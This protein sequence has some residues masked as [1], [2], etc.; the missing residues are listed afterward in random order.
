MIVIL[1]GAPG[2]GKGTQSKA[3][4]ALYGF[5]HLST[6]DIFRAE[7]AQKTELGKKAS[8]YVKSGK[9]VP[10][11]VVTEMVAGKLEPGRR[12]LLDGFPRNVEQAR[13]L[14]GLLERS[15]SSVDRVILL[16]LPQAEALKRLTSRRVCSKCGAVY[17]TLTRPPKVEGRCDDCEGELAQREDDSEATAKKRWMVFEDLTSPL[18]AYYKAEGVFARVD[19]SQE[20][21]AVTA[22]L[23]GL[24]D[25]GGAGR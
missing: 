11:A 20:P 7:I 2:S 10:D 8:E 23:S 6:G 3:L 12:Y 17:N 13:S 19:A 15:G 5:S 22:A 4:A 14:D 24:V 18:I 1:L 16:E 9:L 25:G 21:E